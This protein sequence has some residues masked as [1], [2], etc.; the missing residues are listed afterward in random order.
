MILAT[1]NKGKLKEIRKI[2][3]DYKI[4]SLKD[5][6]IDIDVEE[7]KDSFLGNAEKKAIEIYEIS[8]EETIADDSGLCIN[9][10]NGFPGV[11]THRFLGEDATDRMRNEYL[12]NEVNKYDDRSAQVICNLVYYDGINEIIGKGILNGFISKE[13]RGSNGFGFDEIFETSNGYTLAE[14]SDDEKNIISAR[15][16]AL[17]DLKK[18]LKNA[19][20]LIK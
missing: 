15:Y 8:H 2:L 10:L 6:N 12:I 9:C 13:C 7:D 1:N 18:K 5:K 20:K 11:M 19:K 16:L 17:M 14:L 4:Y 3:S